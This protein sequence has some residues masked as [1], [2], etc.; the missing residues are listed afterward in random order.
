MG[1]NGRRSFTALKGATAPSDDRLQR[2]CRASEMATGAYAPAALPPWC[3]AGGF[4][5][6]TARLPA[7]FPF[8]EATSM[9]VSSCA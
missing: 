8:L 9:A 6:K 7:Y 1:F 2:G 3:V 4:D 5:G